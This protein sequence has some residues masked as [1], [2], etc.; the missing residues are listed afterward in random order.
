MSTLKTA[1]IQHPSASAPAFVLA[2]DGS[3]SAQFNIPANN[4]TSAYVLAATDRNKHINITTGGITVPSGVFL[5]GDTVTI[6]NNSTSDQTITQGSGV[7]LRL[8][9]TATTGNRTL[10]QYGIASLMCVS[11]D[12]FVITGVGLS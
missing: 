12:V 9:G 1:N 5:A 8:P 10:A 2:A 7:T 4:Q 6:Y 11:A 3:C